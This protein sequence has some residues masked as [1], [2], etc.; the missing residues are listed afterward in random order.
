M[1]STRYPCQIS[2]KLE[3]LYRYSKN[4]Q[5]PDVMKIRPVETQLCHTDGQTDRRDKTNNQFFKFFERV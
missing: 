1:Y 5:I 2:M 3:F 4:T